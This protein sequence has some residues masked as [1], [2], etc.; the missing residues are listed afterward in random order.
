MSCAPGA[1]ARRRYLVLSKEGRQPLAVTVVNGREMV[2]LDELSR[3][4]GVSCAKIRSRAA[5]C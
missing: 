1:G 4:F 5:W 2:S 3:L